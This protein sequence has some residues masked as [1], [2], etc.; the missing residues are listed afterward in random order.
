MSTRLERSRKQRI[1]LIEWI[2]VAFTEDSRECAWKFLVLGASDNI[3]EVIVEP[4]EPPQ[5]S[6]PDSAEH[7]NRC[8]HIL[9]VLEQ[10]LK[11]GGTILTKLDSFSYNEDVLASHPPTS[12]VPVSTPTTS[13]VQPSTS[14][15]TITSSIPTTTTTTTSSEQPTTPSSAQT[16]TTTTSASLDEKIKKIQEDIQKLKTEQN[17]MNV[18]ILDYENKKREVSNC[19]KKLTT[20]IGGKKRRLKLLDSLTKDKTL[21]LEVLYKKRKVSNVTVVA[22]KAIQGECSIC[23]EEMKEGTEELDWCKKSC[24]NNFHFTCLLRYIQCAKKTVC[25]LCRANMAT[26]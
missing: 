5:C 19:M 17:E 2:P 24:G 12:T 8:K 6:C 1:L 3:Y 23:L 25:P 15:T 26:Q 22:R 13:S 16:T 7:G 9:F 4:D 20:L 14:V 10:V 21:E 18:E 11:L